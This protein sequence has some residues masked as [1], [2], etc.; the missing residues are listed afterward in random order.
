M[1]CADG[2]NSAEVYC[3]AT[4]MAQAKKVFTPAVQMADRLPS[5]RSK[6]SISVWVD[7]L[8]RPDGSLFAPIAGKPVTVTAHTARSLMNIMSTTRI[9][10][11]KP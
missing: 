5:L 8:T 7:S 4:T 11:M 1:F 3:G 9:T 10:C 6:F 2:E